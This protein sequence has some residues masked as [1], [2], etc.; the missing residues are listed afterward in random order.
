MYAKFLF[1]KCSKT[2]AYAL[3][4]KYL[5]TAQVKHLNEVDL[6]LILYKLLKIKFM[7]LWNRIWLI[8]LLWFVVDPRVHRIQQENQDVHSKADGVFVHTESLQTTAWNQTL[9]GET[10]EYSLNL[11][12]FSP[13]CVSNRR[14]VFCIANV[15]TRVCVPI[16]FHPLPPPASIQPSTQPRP[17]HFCSESWK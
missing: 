4:D 1:K 11:F 2:L 16:S 9:S 13:L 10:P 5:Q 3:E 14:K 8:W 7:I 17:S 6:G 12:H 15:L